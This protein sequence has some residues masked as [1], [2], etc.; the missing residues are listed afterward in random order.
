MFTTTLALFWEQPVAIFET[1]TWYVP[2]VVAVYVL[3]LA[4]NMAPAWLYH[5]YESPMSV[6]PVS[7]TLPQDTPGLVGDTEA[8]GI[9]FTVTVTVFVSEQLPTVPVTV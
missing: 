6:L 9:A 5:W 8:V 2:D 7:T 3:V 1:C 4:P